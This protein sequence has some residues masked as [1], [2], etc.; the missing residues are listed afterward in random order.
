MDQLL[1]YLDKNLDKYDEVPH[2]NIIHALFDLY[3]IRNQQQLSFATPGNKQHFRSHKYR[4]KRGC[5]KVAHT[6]QY[7]AT[8]T[9]WKMSEII[10]GKAVSERTKLHLALEGFFSKSTLKKFHRLVRQHEKDFL[11]HCQSIIS[12]NHKTNLEKI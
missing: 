5:R 4:V 7:S 12:D 1:D 3:D 10:S 2:I 9:T 6:D 8:K 11:H